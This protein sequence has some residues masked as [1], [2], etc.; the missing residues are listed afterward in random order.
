MSSIPYSSILTALTPRKEPPPEPEIDPRDPASL[1]PMGEAT[2]E[3]NWAAVNTFIDQHAQKAIDFFTPACDQADVNLTVFEHGKSTPLEDKDVISNKIRSDVLTL[4]NALL[5]EPVTRTFEATETG[6]PPE[7]VDFITPEG[8][9]GQYPI[10]D[11]VQAKFETKL[12][13][14][15]W[16]RGDLDSEIEASA[17]T[18]R[19]AGWCLP[20]YMWSRQEM[21]PQLLTEISLRQ[22]LLDPSVGPVRAVE[23]AN[24]AILRWRVNYWQARALFPAIAKHLDKL[25]SDDDAKPDPVLRLGVKAEQQTI[26][27]KMVDLS[28]FW[29]RNYPVQKMTPEE[30]VEYGEVE[31]RNIDPAELSAGTVGQ[32]TQEAAGDL[33]EG[34]LAPASQEDN[35]TDLAADVVGADGMVGA[36][37]ADEASGADLGV[38]LEAESG[39][40]SGGI[41]QAIAPAPRYFLPD[42]DIEVTPESPEWP[43]WQAIR[44]ITRVERIVADDRACPYWD[45]P[46]IHMVANPIPLSPCGQGDPQAMVSMQEGRNRAL[47]SAVEHADLMAHPVKVFPKSAWAQLDARYK[48]DGAS[49][50][51]LNVIVDDELY[52]AL[53]GKI[54][55]TEPGEPISAALGQ[56]LEI[57]GAELDDD[58]QAPKV[59]QGKQQGDMG[60]QSI[61]LLQ[62]QATSRFDLPAKF[63]EKMVKRLMKLV[64]W[65]VLWQVPIEYIMQICSDYP[66]EVVDAL[67][68]RGRRNDCNAT[69]MVNVSS[70]GVRSRRMAEA[71]EKRKMQIISQQT[72][73]ER[74]DEEWEREQQ[75]MQQERAVLAQE[76]MAQQAQMQTTMPANA[77]KPLNA[78]NPT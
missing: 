39:L 8:I 11:L 42:T 10:N 43:W 16:N 60:W 46:L 67:I 17:L 65:S 44:Q 26:G 4:V 62:Q 52:K 73:T 29:L 31:Q 69:A 22:V 35:P 5:R 6:E 54:S 7:V 15:F 49:I 45:I 77:S 40:Q 68:E 59:L 74:L 2:D 36:P 70:G 78:Q 27:E 25:A 14:F 24:W 53:G 33:P 55:V 47:T 3:K 56:I 9:P 76:Q 28:F 75:R 23:K 18:C 61:Q 66:P 63:L 12:V 19:I 51:G 41:L 20:P 58:A 32:R 64:R 38:D 48:G 21:M 50:A 57:L 30:A 72:L 34:G 13:D 37:S 1:P 71:V